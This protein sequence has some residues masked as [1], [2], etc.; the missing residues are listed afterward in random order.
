MWRLCGSS[1]YKSKHI[2]AS[3]M[4]IDIADC[5]AAAIATRSWVAGL[6]VV[7]VTASGSM[8]IVSKSMG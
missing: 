4:P 5:V 3:R 8:Y 2:N 1:N 7:A 6:Y